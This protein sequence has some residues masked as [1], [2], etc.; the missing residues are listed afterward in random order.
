MSEITSPFPIRTA[1]PE[2]A[3]AF[4][5]PPMAAFGEELS[6]VEF[7]EWKQ[8]L[9]TDRLIAAFDGEMPIGTAGAYS[10]Q[11][12][13]PGGEV[14]AAGVTVVGVEPG[15]R[16]TRR[17]PLADAP[18]DRRRPRAGRAGGRP[19]GVRDRDLPALRLRPRNAERL[20]RDRTGSNGLGPAMGAGGRHA[21]RRRPRGPR[22]VSSRV[23]ADAG[24]HAGCA[25]PDPRAGGAGALSTTRSTCGGAPARSSATCTR[26]TA[27]PRG[28]RSTGPRASG[29][30]GG[31]RASCSSSRRWRS[32]RVPSA[33]SG[34]SSSAST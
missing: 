13:V 31:R 26:W 17:P 24:R 28:T 19:V 33:R 16:R 18:P 10:F 23:R 34:A 32:R 6:D 11:M 8:N 27:R 29:T 9:E 30:T 4:L 12:T 7:E 14:A 3:R 22:D 1:T 15:H 25:Q 21:S 5:A 20:L 2:T